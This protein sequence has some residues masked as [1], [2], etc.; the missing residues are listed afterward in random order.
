MKDAT[1]AP[2]PATPVPPA[3]EGGFDQRLERLEGIVSELEA[4]EL[5]LEPAIERYQEGIELLKSCH[6]Q[7]ASYRRR[8]EELTADAERSLRPYGKDPDSDPERAS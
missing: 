6:A 3:G 1:A 7:L 8:V 5:G 4:G 2:E